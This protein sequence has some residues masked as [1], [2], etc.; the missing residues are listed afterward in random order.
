MANI[1][2]GSFKL[3]QQGL[4]NHDYYSMFSYIRKLS[5]TTSAVIAEQTK[6]IL[7]ECGI[8][9]RVISDNDIQ[10]TGEDSRIQRTFIRQHKHVDK[11][12]NKL[13]NMTI[14]RRPLL[15]CL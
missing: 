8:P 4:F 1:R 15:R 9:Q 3:E 5:T 13:G 7:S 6:H 12:L 2:N 11:H 10:F 14:D